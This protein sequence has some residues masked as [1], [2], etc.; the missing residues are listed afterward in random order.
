MMAAP[1]QRSLTRKRLKRRICSSFR[2]TNWAEMLQ[3]QN[4]RWRATLV[5]FMPEGAECMPARSIKG[6]G[7]LFYG[8]CGW[9]SCAN[10]NLAFRIC[11]RCL[12]GS[13][14]CVSNCSQVA[15]S[16]THSNIDKK[17]INTSSSSSSSRNNKTPF[18]HP[19]SSD[20]SLLRSRITDHRGHHPLMATKPTLSQGFV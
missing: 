16:H 10:W 11:Q 8:I 9:F 6:P 17:A 18:I 13:F 4:I 20:L 12:F 5:F 7:A 15:S 1:R 19:H 14:R 3:C 2:S